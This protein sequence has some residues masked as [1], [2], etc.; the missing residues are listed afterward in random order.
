MRQTEEIVRNKLM[1]WRIHENTFSCFE[2]NIS[3]CKERRQHHIAVEEYITPKQRHK[4]SER[5]P[6][7]HRY[8]HP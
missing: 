8:Y 3:F 5:R 6:V 1:N 7:E 2:H 4:H